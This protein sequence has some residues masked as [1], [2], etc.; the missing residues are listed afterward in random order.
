MGAT[1]TKEKLIDTSQFKKSKGPFLICGHG[2]EICLDNGK[3]EIVDM[4]DK[5]VYVTFTECGLTRSGLQIYE[6][7]FKDKHNLKYLN[8]PIKYQKELEDLFGQR[9]HVH[10]KNATELASRSYVNIAYKL[11][12]DHN[13]KDKCMI[14]TSGL[15]EI[16]ENLYTKKIPIQSSFVDCNEKYALHE[17]FQGSV[18]PSKEILK[19]YMLEKPLSIKELVE[20]IPIIT[21]KELFELKPGIYY[22]PLCRVN[23][24]EYSNIRKRQVLSSRAL[25]NKNILSD[26]EYAIKYISNVLEQC[27]KYNYCELAINVLDDIY[28][29]YTY[30]ELKEIKD[31]L[32]EI[33]EKT[34]INNNSKHI[35]D[36]FLDYLDIEIENKLSNSEKD[37]SNL[38]IINEVS[39]NNNNN[40]IRITKK[41]SFSKTKVNFEKTPIFI[42]KNGGKRKTRKNK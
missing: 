40:N 42:N 15:I 28:N 6:K 23:T 38:S 5:C 13:N 31:K 18:Y 1:I 16:T 34:K 22:N 4:P 41:P 2:G 32:V 30:D 37:N 14:E 35:Y 10:H 27:A 8:N 25:F 29:Y 19:K 39:N 21:Q 26:K 7:I 11:I 36:N 17:Y 3:L 24:C 12:G 9:I 33:F 20:N